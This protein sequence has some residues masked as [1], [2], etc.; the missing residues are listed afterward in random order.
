MY[1]V[2][3]PRPKN[4]DITKGRAEQPRLGTMSDDWDRLTA[5]FKPVLAEPGRPSVTQ[6]RDYL[7]PTNVTSCRA[8]Q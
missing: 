3:A 5:V 7:E 8:K 4:Y 1:R 6:R 2:G